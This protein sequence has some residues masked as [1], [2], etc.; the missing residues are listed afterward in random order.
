MPFSKVSER[1][2][3]T[4]PKTVFNELNLKPGDIVEVVAEKGKATII[5][6]RM[7]SPAP[8]PKLSKKEQQLLVSSEK[9]IEAI[10]GDI[11]NSKGLTEAEANVTAKVGLIDPEQKWWWLESWQKKEREAER[12]EREGSM[13]G[14]FETAEDLIAHL[15]K[16]RV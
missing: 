8:A 15:H 11:L 7:V 1:H 6:R 10:Q 5:P 12:D 2:Q 9:K 4:I 13:S 16:Q 3:I 14:P